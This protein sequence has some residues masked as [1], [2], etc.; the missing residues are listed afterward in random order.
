MQRV[1]YLF[2]IFIGCFFNIMNEETAK[3]WHNEHMKLT[4][5]WDLVQL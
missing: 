4:V 3:H 5:G 1:C 2:I